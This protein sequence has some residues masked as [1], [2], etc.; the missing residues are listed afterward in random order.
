LRRLVVLT[1][2]PERLAEFYKEVFGLAAKNFTGGVVLTDGVMRLVLLKRSGA[3]GL[4]AYGLAAHGDETLRRLKDLDMPITSEPDWI[5][6]S[7]RQLMLR[8]PEGNLAAI[9][10]AS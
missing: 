10:G 4:Y 8:D 5:D 6:T 2:N 3:S 9:F 7:K 1:E